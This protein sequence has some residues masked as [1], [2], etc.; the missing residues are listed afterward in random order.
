MS[1]HDKKLSMKT[2][3]KVIRYIGKYRFLLLCSVLLAAISVVLTL[4]IPILTGQ[5]IDCIIGPGNV[6]FDKIAGI[7][8]TM[9]IVIITTAVLQWIMN[10]CNNKIAYK[11]VQNMRNEA[12]VKLQKLP[13]GF[14]DGKPHGDI[15]SRIITDV[16]QF[17]DG[18]L[19]G[20]TQLFTGIVTIVV[21]LIFMLMINP[22]ITAVVVILTPLS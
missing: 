17:S 13:L 14:V 10:I 9:L 21:T 19:M 20:F 5:V 15:V 2:I 4:Y 1:K 8:V 3:K 6:D 7:L 22:V 12:F 18:L 16:E 11:V